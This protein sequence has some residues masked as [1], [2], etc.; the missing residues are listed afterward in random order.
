MHSFDSVVYN[1]LK[2]LE[3][4]N[5]VSQFAERIAEK[6]KVN[7]STVRGI[8]RKLQSRSLVFQEYKRGPYSAKPFNIP[9]HGVA[10]NTEIYPVL[11]R[12]QNLVLVSEEL[13]VPKGLPSL[14]YSVVD[15]NVKIIFG[16]KRRQVSAIISCDEGLSYRELCFAVNDFKQRV[17]EVLESV[18]EF[19]VKAKNYE[20]L[21]DYLGI[22]LE[23]I[24]SITLT[25]FMA[26]LEKL[27]NK[28]IGLR[29]EVK[30]S[31]PIPV[32]TL[33][34]LMQGGVSAANLQQFN[35]LLVKQNQSILEFH[36]RMAEETRFLL[37]TV[38]ALYDGTQRIL[39]N[40]NDLDKRLRE[41][42]GSRLLSPD[43][44]KEA[45]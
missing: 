17:H 18:P 14:T 19:S 21:K 36:K 22:R 9:T 1:A 38:K 33:I 20:F 37:P 12:V 29:H 5:Q 43:G 26:L 41:V 42:E 35:F 4:E 8:L 11:P 32:E 44:R 24:Q 6:A 10:G 16:W 15:V 45:T 30:G 40:L 27:Y 31:V 28:E 23:G 2:E 34:A 25:T 39:H 7:F 13:S 3:E